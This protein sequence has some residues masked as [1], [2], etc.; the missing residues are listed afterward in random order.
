MLPNRS[1]FR[2]SV[3]ERAVYGRDG[4]RERERG[5]VGQRRVRMYVVRLNVARGFV[6]ASFI[7]RCLLS[8][9]RKDRIIICIDVVIVMFSHIKRRL[10]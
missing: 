8:T 5:G 1:L 9:F 3:Y 6:R 4:E 7:S 2:K 10:M